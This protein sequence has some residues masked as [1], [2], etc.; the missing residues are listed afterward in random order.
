MNEDLTYEDMPIGLDIGEMEVTLDEETVNDRLELIRWE[1]RES[2]R[3]LGIAPPGMGVVQHAMMQFARFPRMKAA[4][5]AKSEHEFLKPM[6][7]G[8]KII[9]R[10]KIID[11]YIKRGRKYAVTELETVDEAGEVLM[12]SWETDIRI[13]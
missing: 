10:G 2:L 13:E 8:S 9:I 6:K 7:I 12:R 3:K 5:W 4:I 11:K 1:D